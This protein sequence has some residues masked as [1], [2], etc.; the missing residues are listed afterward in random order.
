[1][2]NGTLQLQQ[3]YIILHT[4]T[5]KASCSS[6]F[7]PH[8]SRTK[9][10]FPWVCGMVLITVFVTLHKGRYAPDYRRFNSHA[11]LAGMQ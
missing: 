2:E 11:Y 9:F 6:V 1:M 5:I 10:W 7:I 3:Q 8:F 4:V